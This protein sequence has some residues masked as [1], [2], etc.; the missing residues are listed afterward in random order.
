MIVIFMKKNNSGN[1]LLCAFISTI[2]WQPLKATSEKQKIL[3]MFPD[4]MS[5]V[6]WTWIKGVI[7]IQKH[8]KKCLDINFQNYH[9][10]IQYFSIVQQWHDTLVHHGKMPH[11]GNNVTIVNLWNAISF[12]FLVSIH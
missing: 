4:E 6:Y 10:K 3:K 7:W 5:S 11:M 12:Y 1:F 8:N 9:I 2:H